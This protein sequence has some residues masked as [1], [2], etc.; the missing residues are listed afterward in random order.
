MVG[1]N[2]VA[3]V[4]VRLLSSRLPKKQLK[5]IGNKRLI[6]W[7]IENIKQ[8]R[9]I[10]KIVITTTDEE[11]NK[12]L[13]DV[14]EEHNIDTFF[15]SD[16]KNDVVGRLTKAAN[17]YS[18]DI[19]VLISGDCPIIWAPSLD[20]RIEKILSDKDLDFVGFCKKN[21]KC[22]IHQSTNVYRRKCWELAN[23][24]SDKPNLRE[25]QFPIVEL[26]PELFRSDS[27]FDDELFYKIKHRVSVD[28]LADLEFMN[29]VYNRLQEKNNKF[30]MLHV[31]EL[32]LSEPQLMNINK[33][34]HQI[35]IYEKQ[36]NVLIAA[37]QN[38]EEAY[39]LA[40]EL[41]KKAV[42]VRFLTRNKNACRNINDKGF[43]T[44]E[45]YS[46]KF[47]FVVVFDNSLKKG[48]PENKIFIFNGMD[49]TMQR[50]KEK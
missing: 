34:V 47:D 31:V 37:E 4:V 17:V 23:K 45:K 19:P 41:T 25:H 2:V 16:D 35:E 33:D 29:A 39:K 11:E 46:D 50:I 42:G 27:V 15:Y 18:A 32:L 12:P 44:V 22:V 1:E 30:D 14:A 40:Y 3:F 48:I 9:F 43:G 5:N 7:T 38:L 13:I 8:S 26:K 36:K 20:K 10:N 21:G 24:L 49:K 28:T 6:D